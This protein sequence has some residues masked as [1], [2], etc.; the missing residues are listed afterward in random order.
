MLQLLLLIVAMAATK[1]RQLT[2]DVRNLQI[3]PTDGGKLVCL[4]AEEADA[5]GTGHPGSKVVRRGGRQC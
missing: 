3:V 5:L 4:T 2:E 1:K